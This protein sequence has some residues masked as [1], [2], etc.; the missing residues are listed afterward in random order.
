MN[1]RKKLI[2]ISDFFYYKK[3]NQELNNCNSIL[4]VGCGSDSPLRKVKKNLY[5]VG[6]DIFKPSIEASKRKKIHD[7]YIV[8][9]INK[10][11][12]LFKK[13]SFDAVITL[14]LIE[15]LEKKEALRL[16]KKMEEI[17]RKKVIILTPN[18]FTKQEE[19]GDN[20]FQVHRSGWTV[21]EFKKYGFTTKGMRGLK[22]LRGE[23]ASLRFKPWFFWG[24][25]STFSEFFVYFY[26]PLA[27]QLFAVKV[28]NKSFK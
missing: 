12:K 19:Y 20:P 23:H 5:S 3:L 6:I 27:Y 9:D 24:M 13:D 22:W 7:K 18:G 11:D 4:D 10:I 14:D 16:I 25:I 26:P 17:A 28:N 1:L 2:E 15:H 8:S 21:K